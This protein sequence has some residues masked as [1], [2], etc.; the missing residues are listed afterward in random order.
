MSKTS[1]TLITGFISTVSGNSDAQDFFFWFSLILL[2][3]TKNQGKFAS[4]Q[5][6]ALN[7]QNAL[8]T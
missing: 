4:S 5:K 8:D 6:H 1:F 3:F 2:I 7:I